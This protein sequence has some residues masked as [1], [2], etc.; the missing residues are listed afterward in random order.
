MFF[1]QIVDVLEVLNMSALV[2]GEGDTL[3]IFLDSCLNDHAGGA[4]MPQVYDLGARALHDPA[5][6]VDCR[7]VAIKQRGCGYDA[8]FV[9]GVVDFRL[10]G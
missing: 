9:G 10:R 3:H 2:A 6:N 7:I 8:D 4:V 5:H 1:Q